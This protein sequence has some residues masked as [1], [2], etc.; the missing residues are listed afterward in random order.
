VLVQVAQL[1]LLAQVLVL[2]LFPLA[3][4]PLLLSVPIVISA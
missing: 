1:V 3:L 4:L 2:Q